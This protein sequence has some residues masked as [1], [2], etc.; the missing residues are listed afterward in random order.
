MKFEGQS[1]IFNYVFS[2]MSLFQDIDWGKWDRN[3]RVQSI[4]LVVA[5][6][7]CRVLNV[8]ESLQNSL[9][10]EIIDFSFSIS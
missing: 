8:K 7:H 3:F 9:K 5:D 1:I 2:R 4:S 6:R 10:G